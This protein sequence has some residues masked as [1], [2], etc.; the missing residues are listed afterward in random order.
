MQ[1]QFSRE[2]ADGQYAEIDYEVDTSDNPLT[3]EWMITAT[4][5][6]LADTEADA[7][8]AALGFRAQY[9]CAKCIL[10]EP[11]HEKP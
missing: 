10:G 5:K 6:V 7:E 2:F 1:A 8:L 9:G 11:E 3:G 4:G